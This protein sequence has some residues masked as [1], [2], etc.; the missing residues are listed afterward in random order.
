MKNHIFSNIFNRKLRTN[1]KFNIFILFLICFLTII[2]LFLLIDSKQSKLLSVEQVLAECANNNDANCSELM[3]FTS[4]ELKNRIRE[5]AKSVEEMEKELRATE[6]LLNEK[7]KEIWARQELLDEMTERHREEFG[8]E[9]LH[10][11]QDEHK[12]DYKLY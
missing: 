3:R 8:Y 6:K 5:K 4:E 11:Y 12:D 2:V 10:D 7:E 9:Y 1:T